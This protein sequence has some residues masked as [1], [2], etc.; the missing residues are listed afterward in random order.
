MRLAVVGSRAWRDR[1]LLFST[2]KG[3][4]EDHI[5]EHLVSGGAEGADHLAELWARANDL[6]FT[7]Y[8]AEWKT[9]GRSAGTR[10][11]QQ[12]VD[13]AD[14]I[15]AFVVLTEQQEITPGTQITLDMAR[16]AGKECWIVLPDGLARC[17]FSPLDFQSQ[18]TPPSSDA[19]YIGSTESGST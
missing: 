6:P 3:F 8:T 5:I 10:R 1:D 14:I 16:R 12:I 7:V 18:L 9:C 19:T 4:H 2:L 17:Y 13:A 11:N 15:L